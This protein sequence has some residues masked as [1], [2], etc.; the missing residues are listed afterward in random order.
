MPMRS[1]RL[2]I[3][4]DGGCQPNPGIMQTAVVARGQ[5]WIAQNVGQGSNNDAEWIALIAA[6]RVAQTFSE[7]NML[8]LG[9]SALV[10][11]QANRLAKCRNARFQEY[12]D[13]FQ[14]LT[15]AMPGKKVR[16]INRSQNLAGIALAS[17]NKIRAACKP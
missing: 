10:I 6:V 15:E 16:R 9:D 7:T 14:R 8:F 4:F 11:S 5:S 2:K 13:E 1:R 17:A 3:Y 12:F